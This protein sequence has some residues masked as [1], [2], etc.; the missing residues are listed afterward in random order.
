MVRA[1]ASCRL[2]YHRIGRWRVPIPTHTEV[3][4]PDIRPR[5]AVCLC[6]QLEAMLRISPYERVSP[7]IAANVLH[8]TRVLRPP[9][10]HSTQTIVLGP[11][12]VA[13]VATS[14]D[15]FPSANQ[16]LQRFRGPW[17]L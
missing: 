7:G 14:F 10:R 5:R 13:V 4:P 6:N 12:D 17:N 2:L 9:R 3:A 16:N 15:R 11:Y 1:A 8:V